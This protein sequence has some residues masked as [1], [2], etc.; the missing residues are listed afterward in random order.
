MRYKKLIYK[1]KIKKV[2]IF[3][4]YLI[5]IIK[6]TWFFPNSTDLFPRLKYFIGLSVGKQI[7]QLFTV[8]HKLRI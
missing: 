4:D 6:F 7:Q 5:L 1:I 2:N 8:I 3:F